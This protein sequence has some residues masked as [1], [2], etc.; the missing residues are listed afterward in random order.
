MRDNVRRV[1]SAFE[2]LP[3]VAVGIAIVAIVAHLLSGTRLY[4]E[5]GSGGLDTPPPAPAER[6]EDVRQ[7][8]TALRDGRARRGGPPLDVDAELRRRLDGAAAA[9]APADAALA[10]EVRQLVIARNERRLRRGEAPLDVEA[11]VARQLRK[12]F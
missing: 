2:I 11:E 7:M 8:L 9:A 1:Q 10:E 6:E 3:F 5:I 12:T 4:D